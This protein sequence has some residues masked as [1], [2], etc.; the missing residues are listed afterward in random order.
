MQHDRSVI[1]RLAPR[2][3]DPLASARARPCVP[4][5]QGEPG[6]GNQPLATRGH[7]QLA[8]ETG[9]LTP[10]C[11][12][13]VLALATG[14]GYAE[15]CSLLRAAAPEWYPAAGEVV[16]SYWR[17]LIAV[18]EGEGIGTA[19]VELPAPRPT[20]LRLVRGGLLD[21]GWYMLRVTDHFLLLR[22][23]GF[24]LASLHDN[25]HTGAV[26]TGRTHGRRK[27]THAVR[28]LGGP[29]VEAG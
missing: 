7:L 28:L 6:Q 22:H 18:L 15:A 27:V 17:D 20:L 5:A 25:R 13:A 9:G 16:T 23:H 10:W 12:P 24:G 21:A 4:N 2:Q 11:G 8:A 3:H 29:L 26:V 14:R 1:A 19:A